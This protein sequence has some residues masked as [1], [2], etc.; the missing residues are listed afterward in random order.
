M[1]ETS[2]ANDFAIR[3]IELEMTTASNPVDDAISFLKNETGKLFCSKFQFLWYKH[4][5]VAA[6]SK[7]I[8]YY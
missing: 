8:S 5:R 1:S 7:N 2:T 6:M 3:I 4:R